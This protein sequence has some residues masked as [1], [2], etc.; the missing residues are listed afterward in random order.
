MGNQEHNRKLRLE[1]ESQR[2]IK[3]IEDIKLWG[4]WNVYR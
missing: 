4:I 1:R 3:E 2:P